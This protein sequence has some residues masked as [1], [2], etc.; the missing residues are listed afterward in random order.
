[1]RSVQKGGG[2]RCDEGRAARLERDPGPLQFARTTLILV[3]LGRGDRTRPE[4]VGAIGSTRGILT[5]DAQRPRCW[6]GATRAQHTRWWAWSRGRCRPNCAP[7]RAPASTEASRRWRRRP[8]RSRCQPSPSTRTNTI[9]RTRRALGQTERISGLR[10]PSSAAAAGRHRTS[11]G[12]DVVPTVP[13]E[14]SR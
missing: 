1:M 6:P 2:V 14:R 13:I 10:Y 9:R 12:R 7:A 11:T 4:D 3:P 8:I 5:V